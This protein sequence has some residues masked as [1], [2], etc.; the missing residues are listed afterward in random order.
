MDRYSYA[1]LSSPTSSMATQSVWRAVA[2]SCAVLFVTFWSGT[3][4]PREPRGHLDFDILDDSEKGPLLISAP[5]G[6]YMGAYGSYALKPTNG[7]RVWKG[8]RFGKQPERFT[9]PELADDLPPQEIYQNYYSPGCIQ[10]NDGGIYFANNPYNS[11]SE[12]CLFLSVTA[13][14]EPCGGKGCAVVVYYHAGDFEEGLGANYPGVD[15]APLSKKGVIGVVPNYRLGIFGT[16]SY[17]NVTGTFGF[18]DQ[19][20]ALKWVQRNIAAFG[21][22]P[23][24]V[25]IMGSSSG[26]QSVAAHL[27]SPASAGLFSAAAFGSGPLGFL[28]PTIEHTINVTK[29]VVKDTGC[30]GDVQEVVIACM[31]S[32][33]PDTLL[34]HQYNTSAYLNERDTQYMMYVDPAGDLPIQPLEAISTGKYPDVPIFASFDRDESASFV[35]GKVPDALS[36]EDYAEDVS[37]VV[38][39]YLVVPDKDKATEELLEMY[40]C[41]EGTDDCR[42]ALMNLA[43]DGLLICPNLNMLERAVS[44]KKPPIFVYMFDHVY[45]AMTT[46]AQLWERTA[47]MHGT[48]YTCAF[49]APSNSGIWTPVEKSLCNSLNSAFAN[50]IQYHNPNGHDGSLPLLPT[51]NF[52]QLDQ[53]GN[54]LVVDVKSEV[55]PYPRYQFCVDFWKGVQYAEY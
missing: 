38:D 19:Q 11:V 8:I 7:T 29:E 22:D 28:Y 43:S 14:L 42:P 32:L 9:S 54:I 41:V 1:T 40:P 44:L 21:G 34:K 31:R 6:K 24:R 5:S 48:D 52:P 51:W 37:Y 35:Y 2:L 47:V 16:F 39:T 33:T 30:E 49:D 15:T 25:T 46:S 27:S 17:G 13:P 36:V 53:S 55:E 4:L 23:D 18:Q 50:F 12:D 3:F 26:A 10:A 20:L 45:T